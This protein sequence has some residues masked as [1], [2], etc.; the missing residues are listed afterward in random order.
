MVVEANHEGGNQIELLTEVRELTK[1]LDSLNDATNTQESCDFPKHWQA[2]HIEAN[3]GMTKELRDIQKVSCA[4]AQIEN[5]LGA[6]EVEFKLPNPPDVNADP[7]IKIEIFRP[8][9]A[10]ICYRVSLA[11]LLER[12]WIDCLNNALCV[13]REPVRAQ[14]PEGVFSRASQ[15]LPVDQFS[16]FMAKLHS[17]HLVAKRNNFN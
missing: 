3:S 16:Y 15:A 1:R 7:T 17:S 9:R 13:Q 5:L 11:K 2:V 4:A 12:S 6:G 14:H 8:V 10:G